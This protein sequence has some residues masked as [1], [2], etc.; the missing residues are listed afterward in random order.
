MTV[1]EQAPT[2]GSAEL[3]HQVQQ[4]YA[5]QMQ[6]LDQ[7]RVEEWAATFTED[8]VFAANAHPEPTVGRAAIIASAGAATADYAARG[9]QRRHWLGMVSIETSG[10][11]ALTAR[12]YAVVLET[13]RGGPAGIKAST[14]C[15]DR[16]VRGA[17]G[18]LVEHRLVTRDDLV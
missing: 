6:L 11:D 7:G 2:I 14:L 17:D 3:Y 15:E 18:W 16:L 5:Q 4:F 10:P 1:T 9:I 13:P 8:G 12:C